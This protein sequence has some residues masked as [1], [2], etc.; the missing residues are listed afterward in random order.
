MVHKPIVVYGDPVLLRRAEPVT[1]IDDDLIRLVK[2]MQDAM[3]ANFG[4]GLAAPQLGASLRVIVLDTS[5]G[6]DPDQQLVLLN[7]ELIDAHG[8]SVAEEGCLSLPGFVTEMSRAASV[9][10][11]GLSIEGKAIEI[12]A[13][14]LPA[15]ALQH[16]IDHLN[17]ILIIHSLN[18]LQRDLFERKW[19]QRQS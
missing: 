2:D 3:L 19:K 9:V 14:G 12:E 6:K 16:E 11:R 10:V 18:P 8:E 15:R 7:P 17:G 5:D 1:K 4:V 13:E